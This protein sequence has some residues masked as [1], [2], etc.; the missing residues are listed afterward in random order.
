METKVFGRLSAWQN[1][2]F[3]RPNST[4]EQ[5]ALKLFEADLGQAASFAMTHLSQMAQ[6][7]IAF[8]TPPGDILRLD[9]RFTTGSSIMPQKRNPDFAEVTRAR[10]TAVGSLARALFE[11]ARGSRS[12]YNR[13]TQWTKYWIMDL[14]DETRGAAPVFAAVVSSVRFNEPVRAAMIARGFMNAVDVAD[15]LARSRG[16][17]FRKCY[18][19]LAEAVRLSSARGALDFD[20]LNRL[21]ADAGIGSRLTAREIAALSNPAACVARRQHAGAPSAEALAASR[22]RLSREW[23]AQRRALVRDRRTVVNARSETRRAVA[24]LLA[25]PRAHSA[26]GVPS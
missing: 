12:G 22:A 5:G 7:L 9:D 3:Y 15:H 8:S 21:I 24:A 23:A 1:W 2:V 17:A 14:M 11:V 18:G 19:I 16:V 4:G 13:D 20:A 25:R 26:S 6:D 10:A